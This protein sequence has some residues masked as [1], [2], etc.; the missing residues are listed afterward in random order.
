[1]VRPPPRRRVA[2]PAHARAH[3]AR[4]ARR[5]PPI[6][7]AAVRRPFSIRDRV[8]ATEARVGAHRRAIE[9]RNAIGGRHVSRLEYSRV[10][11][12]STDARSRARANTR[13]PLARFRFRSRSPPSQTRSRRQ[14][15]VNLNRDRLFAALGKTYTEEEFDELCFEFGIELDEVTSEKEMNSKF[16]GDKAATAAGGDA[17]DEVIYKIDIPAN[18]YDLLCHEGISKALNVFM[19]RCPS[20][21]FRLIEPANGAPRQ[22]MVV[23][24][25]TLLVRPF[26]VCAVLRGVRFDQARY[27]SF[28]DLQDK[29]HQ[30]ICRKRTLVAIGTHDLST[31]QGPF[32]YEAHPPEDISFTPLKQTRSFTA[33]ELM[34]HYKSDQKLKHF[35]HIL[36]GSAVFPVLYDANRTV[37]SLPPLINGGNDKTVRFAS[38]STGNT[39]LPSRMCR[40]CFSFWSLL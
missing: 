31:I 20:P 34:E 33:A 24:P 32:T 9:A 14:P 17:S 38:Y 18:R 15:T 39:A 3:A 4:R 37:L 22:K 27:D 25:E 35:L 5:C 19:G 8:G 12:P 21:T 10:R 7:A 40:K 6:A 11:P 1:M 16:L 28:I 36:E 29:L 23:K 30:N 26:V 2:S 13:S